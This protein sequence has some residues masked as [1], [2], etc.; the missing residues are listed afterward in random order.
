MAVVGRVVKVTGEPKPYRAWFQNGYTSNELY[1][2]A[3]DAQRACEKQRG[4]TALPWALRT[5]SDGVEE[6]VADV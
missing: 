6:W 4:G 3:R 1:A 5:R 2:S